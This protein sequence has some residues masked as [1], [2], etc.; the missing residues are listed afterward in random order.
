[1]RGER[2]VR[3]DC[4]ESRAPRSPTAPI[5]GRSASGGHWSR[6][7]WR[8]VLSRSDAGIPADR[9]LGS[10]S[11]PSR[12][13]R[14]AMSSERLGIRWLEQDP[15][16]DARRVL[17]PSTHLGR[18]GRQARAERGGMGFDPAPGRPV[19]G[20]DQDPRSLDRRP[21]ARVCDLGPETSLSIEPREH[22]L[23]V[24][25]DGL[26]L[27]HQQDSCSRMEAQDVDRA[28]LPTEIE[29]DLRH[30]LPAARFQDRDRSFDE[31]GVSC[32]G[33]SVEPFAVP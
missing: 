28:S 14:H 29:G 10:R 4:P 23:H 17:D 32:I 6:T 24:R 27:D 12:H 18:P 31:V 22:R 3:P 21:T 13:V 2:P 26:H 16:D 30:G 15:A 20:K 33:Q 9:M 19:V 7:R 11:V 25:H 5:P 8:T 1:M